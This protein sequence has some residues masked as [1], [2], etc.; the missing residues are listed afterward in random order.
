MD[1]HKN[2]KKHRVIAKSNIKWEIHRKSRWHRPFNIGVF[3]LGW[4]DSRVLILRPSEPAFTFSTKPVECLTNRSHMR[5][6]IQYF[7]V[8]FLESGLHALGKRVKA[9]Y[10]VGWG[11]GLHTRSVCWWSKPCVCGFT[12]HNHSSVFLLLQMCLP[13]PAATPFS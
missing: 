5:C 11:I 2:R 13:S 7:N 6:C 8:L 12:E 9:P 4:R 1:L 10:G 3:S